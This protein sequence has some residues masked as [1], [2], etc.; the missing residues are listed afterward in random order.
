[1][2]DEILSHDG[3]PICDSGGSETTESNSMSTT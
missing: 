1:M 2:D 3:N